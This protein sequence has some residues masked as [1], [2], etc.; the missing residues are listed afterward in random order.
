VFVG[1][2]RPAERGSVGRAPV[3]AAA[4]FPQRALSRNARKMGPPCPPRRSHRLPPAEIR[5]ARRIRSALVMTCR[6]RE[7]WSWPQDFVAAPPAHAQAP[8]AEDLQRAARPHGAD[9]A[10]A[11]TPTAQRLAG[12]RVAVRGLERCRRT[13]CPGNEGPS[14]APLGA[15]RGGRHL[16]C[17]VLSPTPPEGSTRGGPEGREASLRRRRL[18]ALPLCRRPRAVPFR[19]PVVSP[20]HDG[21]PSVPCERGG[22]PAH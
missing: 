22:H 10:G 18:G 1:A 16:A 20:P 6:E 14:V 8:P 5:S 9:D 15:R 2:R 17:P 4:A 19:G 12:S 21:T 7:G 3:R 13:S 11:G